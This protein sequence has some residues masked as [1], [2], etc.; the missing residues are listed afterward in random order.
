VSD[1]VV[2]T[3]QEWKTP[4][5]QHDVQIFMG[6]A[7]I[8]RRFIRNFSG[9]CK[10]ITHTLKGDNTNFVWSK[11]CDIALRF[12]KEQFTTASIL[13]HLDLSKETIME[14]DTSDFTIAGVL[15]QCHEGGL[16]PTA[17]FSRKLNPAEM[18]YEIY[19]KEMLTIV[20]C[21]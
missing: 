8:Y 12:L 20:N 18:N 14:N 3:I 10:P 9:V 2:Q 4:A 6:F 5:S 1:T 21:F 7:N 19:D 13:Q 11:A 16:H 17:F 15:S